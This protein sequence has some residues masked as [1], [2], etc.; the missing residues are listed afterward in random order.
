M[1]RILRYAFTMHFFAPEGVDR[2][3]HTAFSA[4]ASRTPVLRSWMGHHLEEARQATTKA[5]EALRLYSSGKE[6]PSEDMDETP[7]GLSWPRLKNG[8]LATWWSV[9]QDDPKEAWR[10]KRFAEAMEASVLSGVVQSDDVVDSFDW[11]KL[12]N[13]TV[14]D[15][16]AAVLL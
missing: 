8:G 14:V 10:S 1:K 7:F 11:A 5:A 15:V 16:S 6:E 4:H 9:G 13:A 2:V 12:G 3:K